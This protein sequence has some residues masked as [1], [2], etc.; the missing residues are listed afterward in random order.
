MTG[1]N[2]VIWGLGLQ[3]GGHLACTEKISWYHS[4]KLPLKIKLN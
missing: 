3:W 4:P 2:P 1:V